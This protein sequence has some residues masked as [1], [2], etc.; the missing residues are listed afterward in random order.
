MNKIF[1]PVDGSAH[2]RQAIVQASAL[3]RLSGGEVRVFHLQEREPS[4][5]GTA[6]FETTADV[7]RLRRRIERLRFRF[8]DLPFQIG[9]VIVLGELGRALR[10]L[11]ADFLGFFVQFFVFGHAINLV[12][13]FAVKSTMGTTRA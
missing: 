7:L 12:S 6:S 2:S 8:F 1:L 13:A 9:D 3:A 11:L 5:A 4:K 10:G